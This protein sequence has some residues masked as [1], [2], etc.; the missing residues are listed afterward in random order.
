MTKIAT[1]SSAGELLCTNN[2]DVK[3]ELHKVRESKRGRGH[4]RS[5]KRMV[6]GRAAILYGEGPSM[7]MAGRSA[8]VPRRTMAFSRHLRVDITGHL[9]LLSWD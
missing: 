9:F 7:V 6:E 8:A 2:Q 1:Q 5:Q 4:R 3:A